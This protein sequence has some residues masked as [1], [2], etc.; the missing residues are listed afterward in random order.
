[1]FAIAANRLLF[2]CH[3]RSLPERLQRNWRNI[4]HR[5]LFLVW[6]I[7]PSFHAINA[8]INECDTNNGNC[9][10]LTTCTNTPGSR[11]C[12]ACPAGYAGTG[13][14]QCS[15]AKLRSPLFLTLRHFLCVVLS[16]YRRMRDEQRLLRSTDDVHE[17]SWLV[18]VRQLPSW[19]HRKRR[20]WLPRH[21][22]SAESE[23]EFWLM[24]FSVAVSA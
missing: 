11:T 19:L 9:D 21:R 16:R 3:F 15:G 4:L 10:P 6:E 8:D 12:S 20:Q 1:M 14:T 7:K 2:L 17:C 13:A 22:V 24:K 23:S 18:L 5:S